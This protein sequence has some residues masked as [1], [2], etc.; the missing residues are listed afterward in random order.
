ML[1][2]HDPNTGRNPSWLWDYVPEPFC[3]PY[4]MEFG[5][6]DSGSRLFPPFELASISVSCPLTQPVGNLQ[7][8]AGPRESTEFFPERIGPATERTIFREELA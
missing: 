7:T 1:G 4:P 5:V 2:A 6:A 8:C 3:R